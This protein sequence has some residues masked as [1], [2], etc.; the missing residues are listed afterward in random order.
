MDY[1]KAIVL[2]I[3]EGLT[4]FLPV[5]STGHLIIG[6]E[7]MG[8]NPELPQWRTFLFVSQLGA[9]AAVVIFFWKD[10]WR[11]TFVAKVADWRNHI[12]VKLIIGFAPAVVAG[13]ALNDF[14]EEHLENNPLAVAGALIVGAIAMELIERRFRKDREMTIDDVTYK[15]A[16][17]IGLAQCLSI[18]PGMSRAACTIMGGLIVGL[19]PRI[20]AQ[21]SFYLAIPTMLGAAGYRLLKYHDELSVDTIG[22]VLTGTGVAFLVALGVVAWFLPYVQKH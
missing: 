1:L 18:W 12:M 9:I 11:Q 14:M 17:L 10:L 8:V 3:V 6:N 15:Q 19:S 5:S 16:F 7:L 2:G 13:L 22:V 4:E 20:A 21:F